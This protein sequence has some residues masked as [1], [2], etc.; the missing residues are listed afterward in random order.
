MQCSPT[1]FSA[2]YLKVQ[3]AE[4]H[5]AELRSEVQTYFDSKPLTVVWENIPWSERFAKS[6][7]ANT[8]LVGAVVRIEKA[9]PDRLA[10]IIGDVVHNL[11]SALDIM[12]CDAVEHFN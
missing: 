3:R 7:K 4:K 9:V 10:P 11:R 12:M 1:K 8:E 6:F 2:S 5:Q